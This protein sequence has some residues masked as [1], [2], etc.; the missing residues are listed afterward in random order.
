MEKRRYVA[1]RQKM[2][3]LEIDD[4]P[5]IVIRDVYRTIEGFIFTYVHNNLITRPLKGKCKE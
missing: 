4:I 5:P 3:L 1:S 2:R